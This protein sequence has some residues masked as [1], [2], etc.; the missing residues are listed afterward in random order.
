MFNINFYRVPT[1]NIILNYYTNID[2]G[3]LI[4]HIMYTEHLALHGAVCQ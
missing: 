1:Y 2:K 4:Y 3:E